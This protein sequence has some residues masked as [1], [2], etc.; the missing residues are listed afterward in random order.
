MSFIIS[1]DAY[2]FVV[3]SLLKNEIPGT[4]VYNVQIGVDCPTD[5]VYK[6]KWSFFDKN[7][8]FLKPHMII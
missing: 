5:K 2:Y 4:Y 1:I 6:F 3:V 8:L 7:V